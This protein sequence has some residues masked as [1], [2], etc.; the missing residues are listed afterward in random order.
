L[1][2][3]SVSA[4]VIIGLQWAVVTQTGSTAVWAVVLGLPAVLA[5]ATVARLLA[6]L[7]AVS[8]AVHRRR[9]QVR[10]IRCKRGGRR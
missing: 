4:G 1:T 9:R 6:V 10:A 7:C 3:T 8:C 2:C 5:G